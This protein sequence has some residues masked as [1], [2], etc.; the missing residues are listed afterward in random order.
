MSPTLYQ[1][2]I[3]NVNFGQDVK[4]VESPIYKFFVNAFIILLSGKNSLPITFNEV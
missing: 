4:V 2:G 3:K 1:S